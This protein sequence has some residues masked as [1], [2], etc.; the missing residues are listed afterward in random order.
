V[1]DDSMKT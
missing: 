1:I